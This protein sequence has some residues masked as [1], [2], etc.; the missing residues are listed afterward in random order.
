MRA[1]M[2]YLLSIACTSVGIFAL[3]IAILTVSGVAVADEPMGNGPP[4][5]CQC[6]GEFICES[7]MSSSCGEFSCSEGCDCDDEEP[8]DPTPCVPIPF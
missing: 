2:I 8:G 1:S 4:V 7:I 6:D 3:C 5:Y